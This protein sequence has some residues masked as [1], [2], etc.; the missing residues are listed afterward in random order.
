MI[1][2][3]RGR[4]E[5]WIKPGPAVRDEQVVLGSSISTIPLSDVDVAAILRFLELLEKWEREGFSDDNR[6]QG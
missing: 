4:R 5:A 6:N 1:L 3:V 2:V